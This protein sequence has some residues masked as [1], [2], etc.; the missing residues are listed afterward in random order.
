M[1]ALTKTSA[2]VAGVGLGML[3][4]ASLVE[5]HLYTL[6]RFE[7]PVLARGSRPVRMLHVTDLHLIP[8]QQ[9]RIGAV[10]RT[11]LLM[12]VAL[13]GSLVVLVFLFS[14]PVVSAFITQPEVVD[15]AQHLLH[16]VTW[17]SLMFGAG[18]IFSGLMRASGTVLVQRG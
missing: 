4:W 12:N 6:R 13:T 9:H 8:R 3:A 18:T 5:R 1:H 10:L 2:A 16:I 7:V 17:S 11:A 15:L 14:R